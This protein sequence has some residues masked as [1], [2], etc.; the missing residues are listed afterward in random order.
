[1]SVNSYRAVNLATGEAKGW[2]Q[3]RLV[4]ILTLVCL[5]LCIRPA[6]ASGIRQFT[7]NQGVIHITNLGG[8]NQEQ[9]APKSQPA[10]VPPPTSISPETNPDKTPTVAPPPAEKK[11]AAPPE[12]SDKEDKTA[13]EN[14]D[15]DE[16][17]K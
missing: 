6:G 15:D 2:K 1:V 17:E 13:P 10:P 3:R 7:D 12:P 14:E 11:P 16:T 4:G 5:S 9:V 8:A